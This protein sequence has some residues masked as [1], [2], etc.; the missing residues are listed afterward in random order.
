MEPEAPL[1]RPG[2]PYEHRTVE[3]LQRLA[4]EREIEGR[5]SMNKDDLIAAL[6]G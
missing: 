6:R 1:H 3:E 4:A 5:A 2:L